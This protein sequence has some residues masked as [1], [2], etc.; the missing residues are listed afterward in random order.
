MGWG[1]TPAPPTM[2]AKAPAQEDMPQAAEAHGL[3]DATPWA[4]YCWPLS[5]QG[6]ARGV[7]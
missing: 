2:P 1:V 7:T 5:R 4:W 3:P 6:H